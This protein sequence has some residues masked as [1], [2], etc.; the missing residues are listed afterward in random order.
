MAPSDK[1]WRTKEAK[2]KG[3]E[4]QSEM[5]GVPFFFFRGASADERSEGDC[6][7]SR[8]CGP[9]QEAEPATAVTTFPFHLHIVL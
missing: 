4:R 6:L 9:P 1:T 5:K 3:N 8:R 2:I 7:Y